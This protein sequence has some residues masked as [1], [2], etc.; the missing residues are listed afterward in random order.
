MAR[1]S[2]CWIRLAKGD[3]QSGRIGD[4]LPFDRIGVLLAQMVARRYR[5]VFDAIPIPCA[6]RDVCLATTDRTDIAK[7]ESAT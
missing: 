4:A 7:H 6:L 5:L 1:E 2:W 3:P